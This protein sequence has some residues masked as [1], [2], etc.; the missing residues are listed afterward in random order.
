[1]VIMIISVKDS[2]K[3]AGISIVCFCAVFVCTFFM[4]YYLDILPLRESIENEFLPLYNAQ[5][6]TAKMTCAITGGFL[7]V[8]A[9]IML[10]FYIKIF[11]DS[12][13]KIIGM[14][15][16]F[17]YSDFF[18]AKSFSVFGLSVLLGCASGFSL[19]W[20]FMKTIYRSLTIDGLT[21]IEPTFHFSLL[22]L[23]V[24]LPTIVFTLIS[25]LFAL[26]KLRVPT[27]ELLKG[28]QDK[29]RNKKSKSNNK[30]CNFIFE[31][32]IT[33]LK[34]KKSL[35]F[36]IFFSCFCFSAMV[37]MGLSMENLVKGTM[38]I[39]IL[40]IGLVLSV[41]SMVMASTVLVRG[42]LK[43]FSLMKVFGYTKKERFLGVFSG[44]LPF[45]L[46]GFIVGTVYQFGLL[47]LMINVFFKD[48]ISISAY[49]FNFKA[50]AITFASFVIVYTL[51]FLFY[52]HK[53]DKESFKAI[54][55]E[56]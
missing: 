22:L 33:V 32:A 14:L 52:A 39:L 28:K 23:A 9:I 51:F 45:T 21:K 10:L 31:S 24:I 49:N 36:F 55:E 5:L 35:A 56:N 42:N 13:S 11:V 19:A 6:S 1:M 25:F 20:A 50:L 15:K 8:I 30:N 43:H 27:M 48:V 29:Y 34:S 44:Y 2:L 38:A 37:Q 3:L 40:I 41:V 16:A 7:F 18:V 12:H 26:L 17:G 54:M 53:A 4:N 47:K 46:F